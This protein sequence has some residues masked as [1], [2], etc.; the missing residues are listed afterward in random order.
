MDHPF[1]LRLKHLQVREASSAGSPRKLAAAVLADLLAIDIVT[2]TRW[3]GF[4]KRGWNDYLAAAALAVN[5]SGPQTLTSSTK[6]T[7]LATTSP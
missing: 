5:P 4:A 2:A 6:P 3:A 1:P 7:A